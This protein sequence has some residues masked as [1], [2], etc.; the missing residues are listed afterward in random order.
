M[1][2]EIRNNEPSKLSSVI[3]SFG[4]TAVHLFS[5]KAPTHLRTKLEQ[6]GSAM[7]PK[8]HLCWLLT[9]ETLLSECVRYTT[10]ADPDGYRP[11]TV[12]SA[13]ERVLVIHISRAV[14]LK[15][16]GPSPNTI[17]LLA[18]TVGNV[19]SL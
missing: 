7:A 9:L 1:A 11:T 12:W 8:P 16:P 6:V 14:P 19:V 10:G 5:H 17:S 4:M 13:E 15:L 2:P 18:L 3:Y